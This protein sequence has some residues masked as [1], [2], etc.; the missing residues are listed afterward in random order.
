M[1]LWEARCEFT[2]AINQLLNWASDDETMQGY[3]IAFGEGLVA[4]T[5]AADGDYDGPHMSGGGHYTGVA[6]DL[7]VYDSNGT[8]ISNGDHKT[9]QAMGAAWKRMH[10]L[11]RWGGDFKSNP[12][13]NHFGFLWGGRS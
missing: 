11:S 7:L 3:R 5:D 2:A 9:Y 13:A 4:Q 8:Y 6:H 12:D 1:K 10:P